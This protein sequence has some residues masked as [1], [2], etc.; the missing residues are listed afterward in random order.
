MMQSCKMILTFEY[1]DESYGVS[2]S[3]QNLFGNTL[4]C[5]VPVGFQHFTKFDFGH[6]ILGVK[7]LRR[8]LN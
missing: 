8:V 4:T 1:V 7:W 2:P 3:K 6:L 5:M